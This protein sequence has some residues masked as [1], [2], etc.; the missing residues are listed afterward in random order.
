MHILFV[1]FQVNSK[2]RLIKLFWNCITLFFM[3]I[4]T[5]QC[6]SQIFCFQ[7]LFFVYFRKSFS[8]TLIDFYN[9]SHTS[10]SSK[11]FYI[12]FYLLYISNVKKKEY[13]CSNVKLELTAKAIKTFYPRIFCIL[14]RSQKILSQ[15]RVM[16]FISA[17]N[18]GVE[19]N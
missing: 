7:D 19:A 12:T 2:Q 5:T 17:V 18:S 15:I 16:P 14:I 13:Y 1:T 6:A 4:V 8:N 11:F 3:K 9:G 10:L